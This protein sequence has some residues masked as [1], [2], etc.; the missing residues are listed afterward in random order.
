MALGYLVNK[1]GNQKA[2]TYLKESVKPAIWGERKMK[3][4][5][6]FH[7]NVDDRNQ[8]LSTMAIL[9]L[10]LS[11]HPSAAETLRSLQTPTTT[12]ADRAFQNQASPVIAEALGAHKTI[13]RDGLAR[14]YGD[15]PLH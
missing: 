1:S 2:L 5:S 13:S 11:G 7:A 15:R 10:A 14:Y 8:R 9:G 4:T 3:W 6:P 12:E